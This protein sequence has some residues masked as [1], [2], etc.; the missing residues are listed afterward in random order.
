MTGARPAVRQCAVAGSFYP[1]DAGILQRDVDRLLQAD[2]NASTPP[3]RGLIVP[4]AGY[5]YSGETAAAAYRQ[6]RPLREQIRRVILLGPAHRVYLQA[7]ALPGTSSFRTPLGDIP[8][9]QAALA[10]A[11]EL[12]AVISNDEAHRLEHSLEVQLPFLQR[13]LDDFSLLPIVV[14]HCPPEAVSGLIDALW[15]DA[16]TLPGNRFLVRQIFAKG[17]KPY[18]VMP[19]VSD[20]IWVA[21]WTEPGDSACT[22][23][24]EKLRGPCLR[25]LSARASLSFTTLPGLHHLVNSQPT[26]VA[27]ET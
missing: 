25:A 2:G 18:F 22:H 10:R 27:L 12:P 5:L 26:E 15:R 14:G 8:V 23:S 7:M 11:L 4:H 24:A 16:D 17:K 20:H 3:P 9:D 13:M 6:L 19:L 21:P 1:A